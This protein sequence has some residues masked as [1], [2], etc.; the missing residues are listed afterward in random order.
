MSNPRVFPV[1][2]HQF[3]SADTS[4]PTTGRERKLVIC[5]DDMSHQS[6]SQDT[7]II[8]LYKLLEKG[9]FQLTYYDSGVGTRTRPAW[10]PHAVARQLIEFTPD[11]TINLRKVVTEAY[12]WLSEVYEPGDQI[13]FFGAF[14]G[15]FQVRM[16]AALIHNVGLLLPG[17]QT[18]IPLRYHAR[19]RL[20]SEFK[21]AYCHSQV[22]MHFLGAWDTALPAEA[23]HNEVLGSMKTFQHVK[24][25][26]HALALDERLEQ[27]LP[28]RLTHNADNDDRMKEVWFAGTRLDL[29]VACLCCSRI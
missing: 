8:E 24:C 15:A 26:R 17:N 18:G 7:C 23:T 28:E 20:M 14:H 10:N 27:L 1:S 16:L 4:V 3:P 6:T 21:S 11:A 29:F 19:D 5:I 13:S 12:R 22:A 2:G 25:F 9:E